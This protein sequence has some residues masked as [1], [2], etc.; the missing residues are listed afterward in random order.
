MQ[1][2][3]SG[4]GAGVLKVSSSGPCLEVE[5]V[6][7]D[8]FACL[9]NNSLKENKIGPAGAKDIATALEKNK[10]LTELK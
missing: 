4:Q 7:S 6:Q 3:S 10:T 5:I 2:S 1:F 8:H 9:K